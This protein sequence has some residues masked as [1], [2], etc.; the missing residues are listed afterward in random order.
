[1]NFWF[2]GGV[3]KADMTE[4]IDDMPN[5]LAWRQRVA[6]LGH[7]I[8]SDMTTAEA[9]AAAAGAEPGPTDHIPHD[10]KDPIGLAPGTAAHVMADDYGR[11]PISGTLVAVNTQ[12]IVI[13]RDD[14]RVGR[15]NVHFPRAGFTAVGA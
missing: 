10:P 3:L 6:A 1:M 7:G 12:R 13:A 15:V 5:I 4:Q 9:I 8:H 14:P 11:D 2:Y